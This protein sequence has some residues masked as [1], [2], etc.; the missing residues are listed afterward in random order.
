MLIEHKDLDQLDQ[1]WHSRKGPGMVKADL[2][3]SK[4]LR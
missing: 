2:V 1:T 3:W 4:L